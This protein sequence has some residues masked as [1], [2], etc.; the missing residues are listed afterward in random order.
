M[1]LVI[2]MP[3]KLRFYQCKEE[4][5]RISRKLIV[6]IDTSV[7]Q[8]PSFSVSI[9]LDKIVSSNPHMLLQLYEEIVSEGTLISTN[10]TA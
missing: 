6:S 2:A 8:L 4:W 5:W 7:I 3:R 10:W 9:P 1:P